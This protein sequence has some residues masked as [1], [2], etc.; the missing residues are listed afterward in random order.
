MLNVKGT[1]PQ[2][3]TLLAEPIP[4]MWSSTK[5]QSTETYCT[6]FGK[7]RQCFSIFVNKT[8]IS[9]VIVAGRYVHG[10]WPVSFFSIVSLVYRRRT[11][12][13]I[14]RCTLMLS[15]GA[16]MERVRKSTTCQP[17]LL[18]ITQCS[19]LYCAESECKPAKNFR[20][21]MQQRVGSRKLDFMIHQDR[22][23]VGTQANFWGVK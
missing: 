21:D 19:F 2:L 1:G 4:R 23:F 6:G 3:H 18:I 16:E 11:R 5:K 20:L 12:V 17:A 9:A 15:A 22:P 7:H 14:Q 8:W 10:T 13:L